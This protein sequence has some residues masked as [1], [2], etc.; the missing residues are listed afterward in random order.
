LEA[1]ILGYHTQSG[2]TTAW[3]VMKENSWTGGR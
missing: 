3:M 2:A 1:H